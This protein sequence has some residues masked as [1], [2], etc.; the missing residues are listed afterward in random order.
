M[1]TPTLSAV[2]VSA[3]P[4]SAST[5]I[6]QPSA[7]HYSAAR[8]PLAATSHKRPC[9]CAAV[10]GGGLYLTS[11]SLSLKKKSPSWVYMDVRR[12]PSAAKRT[13][14]YASI[15][16]VSKPIQMS[17]TELYC[18]ENYATLIRFRHL[19]RAIT[20]ITSISNVLTFEFFSSKK[21]IFKVITQFTVQTLKFNC[22]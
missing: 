6:Q 1:W 17:E 13:F 22:F 7:L 10:W 2:A 5:L 9:P 12:R 21:L 16:S 20:N 3:W 8:L 4:L 15:I 14:E 18:W 19:R 11:C